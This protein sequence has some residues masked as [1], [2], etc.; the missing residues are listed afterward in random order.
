[1]VYRGNTD[2]RYS[3]LDR[4]IGG[5]DYLRSFLSQQAQHNP[6]P[7]PAESCAADTLTAA[8]KKL[9]ARLM[10]V[11]HSGEVA[12]QGLYLAQALVTQDADVRRHMSDT[13]VE[14]LDH[15][16]WCH[17]RL[18][19]LHTH[20]SLLNPLW[21]GGSLLMGMLA[22]RQ[23]DRWN[24]GFVQETEQQVVRHLR[25]HLSLLPASDK[26]S[27]VVLEKMVEDEAQHALSAADAGA[28]PLPVIARYG[29]RITAK[30][31]TSLALYI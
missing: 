7:S 3:V 1:M 25:N 5:V 9:A 18:A 29:M 6:R 8:D 23:G 28:Q 21:F 12:A 14:E 30:V 16:Y 19:D 17:Q 22:A 4:F 27:R 15:L 10:R 2:R 26:R 20:R 11:N 13:A 24:L 31:M